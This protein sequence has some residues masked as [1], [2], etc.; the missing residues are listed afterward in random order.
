M[1]TTRTTAPRSRAVGT[2]LTWAMAFALVACATQPDPV[3]V[4]AWPVATPAPIPQ[5]TLAYPWHLVPDTPMAP[6]VPALLPMAAAPA[7][8]VAPPAADTATTP[9]PD[10]RAAQPP[11]AVQATQPRATTQAKKAAPRRATVAPVAS[12]T[13]PPSRPRK[14]KVPLDCPNLLRT[15]PYL[16]QKLSCPPG[17]P[18]TPV[19]GAGP[20]R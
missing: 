8:S 1:Q 16:A 13:S 14:P 19:Q 10:H 20:V 5:K 7:A 2:A 4:P 17:S 3:R 15:N 18:N 9:L 11:A 6:P 12:P